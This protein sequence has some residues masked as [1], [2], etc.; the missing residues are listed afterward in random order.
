MKKKV[1]V[2][3]AYIFLQCVN[4]QK[5]DVQ[6][7]QFKNDLDLH[8]S[9]SMESESINGLPFPPPRGY[10]QGLIG[11][12]KYSSLAKYGEVKEKLRL[13][14]SQSGYTELY[15]YTV[16]GGFAMMTRVEQIDRDGKPLPNARLRWGEKPAPRQIN[17]L[18]NYFKAL[19][20]ANEG[21]YRIFMF[22]ITDKPFS[23]S[24]K[25]MTKEYA[26]QI[27]QSGL[28]DI[29]S[30]LSEE[31]FTDKHQIS[32]LVYEFLKQN[33]DEEMKIRSTIPA[34]EHLKSVGLLDKL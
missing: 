26:D 3:I 22:V 17:S 14:L 23:S 34:G 24:D 27:K 7:N 4:T 29:P 13:A 21:R 5:T 6:Q 31:T 25:P 12:E 30:A 10:S 11:R 20:Q 28:N 32:V 9:K 16:P 8:S 33:P 2:L 18:K 1:Y 19:F 15:Y